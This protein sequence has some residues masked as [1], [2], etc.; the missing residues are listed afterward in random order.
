VTAPG[1]QDITPGGSQKIVVNI[2]TRYFKK[3][4][5]KNIEVETNDPDTPLVTLTMKATIV[6]I[7][8]IS[9]TTIDFGKV[10]VGSDARHSITITNKGKEALTITKMN[11]APAPVLSVSPQGEVKIDPGR[12]AS[13]EVRFQPTQ[14]EEYFF[15]RV[16][17]TASPDNMEKSVQITA[18]IVKE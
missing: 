15:G 18:K 10:K 6:E 17:L 3:S 14:V 8:S 9:P 16:S 4:V 11:V 12:T 7:L 2:S 5:L 13:F 1:G